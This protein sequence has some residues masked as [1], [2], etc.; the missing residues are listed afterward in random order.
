MRE[1]VSAIAE[2]ARRW[3]YDPDKIGKFY[4]EPYVDEESGIR[5]Y[6]ATYI[7]AG[8]GLQEGDAILVVCPPNA[9]APMRGRCMRC[10]RRV[11][12]STPGQSSETHLDRPRVISWGGQRV[13]VPYFPRIECLCGTRLALFLPEGYVLFTKPGKTPARVGRGL[14]KGTKIVKG[15]D[16]QILHLS[17]KCPCGRTWRYQWS[18]VLEGLRVALGGRGSATVVFGFDTP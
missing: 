11:E 6:S 10:G 16:G 7:S 18:T 2:D 9:H 12:N 13:Q 1:L 3:G 5:S 15:E 17:I 8:R 14:R 4:I